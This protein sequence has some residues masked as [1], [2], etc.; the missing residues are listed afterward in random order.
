[1]KDAWTIEPVTG[2][3]FFELMGIPIEGMPE[4][5]GIPPP[6]GVPPLERIAGDDATTP[7]GEA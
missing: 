5:G 3:I 2:C 4:L 1:V 6:E 7:T